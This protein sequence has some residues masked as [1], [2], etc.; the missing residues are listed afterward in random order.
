MT[1]SQ[2]F[3][4]LVGVGCASVG[5]AFI[6]LAWRFHQYEQNALKRNKARY[7][8]LRDVFKGRARVCHDYTPDAIVQAGMSYSFRSK[9]VVANGRLSDEVVSDFLGG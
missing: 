1:L 4:L 6:F 3:L 9:K 5:M 8:S 7:R 2:G